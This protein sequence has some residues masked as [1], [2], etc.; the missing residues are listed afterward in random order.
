MSK[1]FEINDTEADKRS[2]SGGDNKADSGGELAKGEVDLNDEQRWDMSHP[3]NDGFVK[4]TEK[5]DEQLQSGDKFVRWGESDKH[6][7][8]NEINQLGS[9]AAPEGTQYGEVSLQGDEQDRIK[10]EFEVQNPVEVTSGIAV[11]YYG[12]DG[13]GTQ[14]KFNEPIDTLWEKGDVKPTGVSFEVDHRTPNDNV[15]SPEDIE[16]YRHA[17]TDSDGDLNSDASEE[18]TDNEA[19][20][21][22]GKNE[23][24]GE[25]FNDNENSD[26][27]QAAEYSPEDCAAFQSTGDLSD[28][29]ATNNG[30]DA[31]ATEYS[32][33]D[34]AAFQSAGDLG[35]ESAT[36]NGDDAQATE[37]SPEDQAAFQNAGDLGD[38]SVTDGSAEFGG[39]SDSGD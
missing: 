8:Y 19:K 31:Q 5:P 32:P 26:D 29:L 1:K 39:G 33:E 21:Y 25:D 20:G 13:G 11:P 2:D 23:E 16:K 10:Y 36:N 38:G 17:N 37:Y 3:D 28:E 30:D 35:N 34:K 6:P 7:D 9:Y 14:H 24:V 27:V 18:N 4:G 22:D 12:Q 15:G